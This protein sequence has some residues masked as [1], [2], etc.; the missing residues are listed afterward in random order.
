MSEWWSYRPSDF[1]LFAP[2]TYYRLVE[3]YNVE[4][5]PWHIVAL[6]AALALVALAWRRASQAGRIVAFGLAI[7][8]IVVGWRFHWNRYATINWAAVYFAAA[9]ALQ[10]GLLAWTALVGGLDYGG[11]SRRRRYAGLALIVTALALLPFAALAG[12]RPWRQ[13]EVAGLAPDPTAILTLGLLLI[14]RRA[15]WSLYA[16]PVLWCL[17]S[18]VTLWTMKS[19]GAIVPVLAALV[20]AVAVV[21]LRLRGR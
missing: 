17:A 6:A 10:A 5:W 20:A 9:F 11:T 18:G 2:R 15:H 14:A 13:L 3:T 21:S 4:S 8:W 1:L 16:V 19:P 7:A 12:G